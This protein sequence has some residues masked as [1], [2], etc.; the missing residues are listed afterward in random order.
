MPNIL[1][2]ASER[3]FNRVHIP[4]AEAEFAERPS[5]KL[6]GSTAR[7]A[8]RRVVTKRVDKDLG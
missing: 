3:H 4:V 6:D 8:A 5:D 1:R 2:T 7:V